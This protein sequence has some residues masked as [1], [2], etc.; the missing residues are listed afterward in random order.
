MAA[1]SLIA[2]NKLTEGVE[3]LVLVGQTLEAC[4]YLQNYGR[5]DEAAT[6]AKTALAPE[7]AQVIL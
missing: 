2:G 3:L 7:D 4:S 6:L 5:W 1:M